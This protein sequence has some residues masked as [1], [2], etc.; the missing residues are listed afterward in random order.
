MKRIDEFDSIL[1]GLQ[2]KYFEYDEPILRLHLLAYSVWDQIYKTKLCWFLLKNIE[3]GYSGLIR[4]ELLERLLNDDPYNLRSCSDDEYNDL[5]AF[6]AF[7]VGEFVSLTKP[8]TTKFNSLFD[9]LREFAYLDPNAVKLKVDES[10]A[11]SFSLH[12]N[13]FS[14]ETYR[15]FAGYLIDD[16]YSG[17]YRYPTVELVNLFV[18]QIN[19]GGVYTVFNLNSGIGSIPLEIAN[20]F[21]DDQ[22]PVDADVQN[23]CEQFLCDINLWTVAPTLGE[24]LAMQR[25]RFD[26][27]RQNYV[28]S[29]YHDSSNNDLFDLAIGIVPSTEDQI[30]QELDSTFYKF[31]HGTQNSENAYVELMLSIITET[32]KAVVVVPTRFLNSS[33]SRLLREAYLSLDWIVSVTD[34]PK[35]FIPES[36]EKMSIVSF[37]RNKSAE[38]KDKV[39]FRSGKDNIEKSS[40]LIRDNNSILDLSPSRFFSSIEFQYRN[41]FELFDKGFLDEKLRSKLIKIIENLEN[42]NEV[43]DNFTPLRKMIEGIFEGIKRKNTQ[44]IPDEVCYRSDESINVAWCRKYL[45]GE[46]VWV[47]KKKQTF[48]YSDRFP[49]RSLFPK[50]IITSV[51]ICLDYSNPNSHLHQDQVGIFAYRTAANALLDTLNWFITLMESV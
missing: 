22:F 48:R 18:D 5:K 1:D 32:G 26:E 37:D 27:A 49:E 15:V 38:Q 21:P 8:K 45:S 40:G 23:T 14:E 16:F 25:N 33:D 28:F 30:T 4:Y 42:M 7:Q 20:R 2:T 19:L 24:P 39:V 46:P 9:L 35:N 3:W 29:K 11:E 51:N 10:F 6:V 43:E 41:V 31:S 12:F 34:V 36:L 13:D 50:Q 44:F 17:T 47:E